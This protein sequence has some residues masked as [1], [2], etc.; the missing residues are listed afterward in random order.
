MLSHQPSSA[1]SKK[2]KTLHLPQ[3]RTAG[4]KSR[5]FSS[6]SSGKVQKT[7][8]KDKKTLPWIPKRK[9]S[10]KTTPPTKKTLKAKGKVLFGHYH[11]LMEE[12]KTST[13]TE[14]DHST[15]KSSSVSMSDKESQ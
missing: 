11:L 9:T 6:K 5:Q 1:K 15:V 12:M 10:E 7:A 13:E 3:T 8:N 14:P 4:K 2:A